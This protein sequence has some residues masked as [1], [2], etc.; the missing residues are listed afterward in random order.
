[1]G[2]ARRR[3][4][5]YLPVSLNRA[6]CH[7]ADLTCTEYRKHPE[8]VTWDVPTNSDVF[9]GTCVNL[10]TGIWRILALIGAD[11]LYIWSSTAVCGLQTYCD[12]PT[13]SGELVLSLFHLPFFSPI[14]YHDKNTQ[15]KEQTNNKKKTSTVNSIFMPFLAQLGSSFRDWLHFLTLPIPTTNWMSSSFPHIRFRWDEWYEVTIASQP[16]QLLCPRSYAINSHL[17]LIQI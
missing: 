1:M 17:I 6:F 3:A 9:L 5:R 7:S 4:D 13:P 2:L 14:S 15:T 16:A 12:T 10:Y 11:Q 8:F